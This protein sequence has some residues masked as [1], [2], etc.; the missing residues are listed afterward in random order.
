MNDRVVETVSPQAVTTQGTVFAKALFVLVAVKAA[1]KRVGGATVGALVGR[2][3]GALLGL[4]EFVGVRVIG[5]VDG[6]GNIG[7]AELG[8]LVGAFDGK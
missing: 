5:A 6:T 1:Q 2:I 3:I 4:S 8:T 7:A